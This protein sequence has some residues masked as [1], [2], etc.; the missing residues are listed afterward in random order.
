MNTITMKTTHRIIATAVALAIILP[1]CDS[2]T[3]FGDINKSPNAPS[4]AYSEY[5][6]SYACRYVPYFV[7][8]SA[9]NG[10]DPWQQEWTGYL[11]ESKN[12]QYGPLGTTSQYSTSTIYLYPLKNLHLIVQMNEDEAQKG[13]PN[14]VSFGS[15]ANQIAA[16]KTLAAFYYMSL[17]DING[18]IILS[19]AFKGAS[20]DNWKPAYDSQESVYTQLD[21]SLSQA[22]R[23]FD[24]SSSLSAADILYKGDISKWKKFN[25][26]LRMLLAIKL[27]DVAPAVGKARFAA[28]YNDGGMKSV[29]DGFNFRYDDLSW[30]MLYYWCS[31]DYS[32]AGFNAVPNMFIVEQM[33]ELKDNRMFK[34]FDI[35]GYKGARDPAKFPRDLHSSFYGNPFGLKDNNAVAAFNNVCCCVN[36]SLLAIDA[37]VPVIPTARVLL[38]EAEAAFR[39]WISADPKTLYEKGIMASF[40]QWGADGAADYIASDGVAYIDSDGLNRIAIQRWIASY[41]SDGVEVWSDWRRLDIPYMPVGPGAIDIGN[42]H[43]PYRIGYYSDTDIAY[44]Y[45]NYLKAVAQLSGGKDDISNRVWWDVADNRTGVL[46]EEQCTPP[47]L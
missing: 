4:T 3:D 27:C 24:E 23:M 46:T 39:G 21:E 1:S 47:I 42:M 26:S 2:L 38:T 13:N 29:S 31:P 34:Y 8:G 9:T 11:S 20:D 10:Y 40:E 15:N 28:A 14:V 5:L 17:T 22:Y 12:N 41:L 18:P 36:S 19:E 7:L 43:Y 33:K 30:N 6:F 25:A 44:N 32:G 16:A 37:T 35:E 45:E